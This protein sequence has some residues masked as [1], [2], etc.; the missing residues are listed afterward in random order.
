MHTAD[1]DSHR[2]ELLA[3]AVPFV[4]AVRAIP[5]VR[6]ISLVGSIVTPRANPK[7]I[8]F[9]IRITDDVDVEVLARHGRRLQGRAQQ[10]NRGADV[11]L[12]DER[13]QYLGRT[14]RWEDCRPGVRMACDARHCGR[15][16]HL[17]DDLDDV[18]LSAAVVAE[19]PVT[20]WPVLVRR[21]A[22]PTD[23]E[24]MITELQHAV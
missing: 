19:P 13:G 20:L 17:H 10:C 8:D 21:V 7:D 3:A 1:T 9:L 5:G 11:F 14:C 18:A 4:R 15:R 2:A 12:A 23:V 24:L 22:L 6:Q 16:P